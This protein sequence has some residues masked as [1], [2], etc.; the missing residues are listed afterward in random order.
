MTVL[1]DL[2]SA[3]S[4]GSVE[5]VDLTAPLQASTP[6]LNLPEPFA[7]TQPFALHE[8]SNY[9]AAGPGWYWNNISTGEHV[10][11]HVD[12]PNHWITGRESADVSAAPVKQLIGPAAVLDASDRVADNPDFL[13]E[14]SDIHAWEAQ[15]GPLPEGGWLLFRTGWDARSHDSAAFLNV[16]EN[17]SHTPGVSVECAKYLAEETTLFGFGVETVGTDA[18]GAGAFDPMFPCHHYFL[19][20]GKFGLTQLQNLAQLPP[21]GAVIVVCPLPIVGGSGSPARVLAMVS[22]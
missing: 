21:T 20:S 5:I 9:D 12:A 4:G 22:R 2:V 17:G 13:L 16:D 8:I 7:N 19:G 10:G 6:I 3:V 15:H 11:T 14:V 1:T 18:G